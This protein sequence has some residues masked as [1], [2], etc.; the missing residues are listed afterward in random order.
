MKSLKSTNNVS[1]HNCFSYLILI[2]LISV[3]KGIKESD[4]KEAGFKY[5]KLIKMKNLKEINT[6]D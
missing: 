6:R 5:I 4:V 2:A 1:N 3:K